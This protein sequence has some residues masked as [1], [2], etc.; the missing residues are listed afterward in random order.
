MLL[1]GLGHFAQAVLGEDQLAG[2]RIRGVDIHHALFELCRQVMPA[3]QRGVV[4]G[5]GE[6]LAKGGMHLGGQRLQQQRHVW[7]EVIDRRGRNAG[8][9]GHRVDA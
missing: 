3:A 9:F 5:K 6:H 8:A 2:R 7:E 4:H 1:V